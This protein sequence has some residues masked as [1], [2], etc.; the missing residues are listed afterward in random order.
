VIISYIFVSVPALWPN[1]SSELVYL[2]VCECLYSPS[3]GSWNAKWYFWSPG[4][5]Y[6][7]LSLDVFMASV[8]QTCVLPGAGGF[9]CLG[10]R[11]LKCTGCGLIFGL[12]NEGFQVIS[13][14]SCLC[15][16]QTAHEQSVYG[17]RGRI[18]SCTY[19]KR[20]H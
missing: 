19:T 5:M 14:R 2:S 13:S 6:T 15:S 10:G 18:V 1:I 11:L 8:I 12:R 20:W 16:C 17:G 9:P 3:I 7:E 4:K